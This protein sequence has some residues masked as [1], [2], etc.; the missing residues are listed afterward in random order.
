[1]RR[2]VP[3]APPRGATTD[4]LADY[5]VRELGR[6]NDAI[7]Q[8]PDLDKDYGSPPRVFDGMLR[9]ADGVTWNPDATH[10][11][12]FY[13]YW[14]GEWHYLACC[15]D[16]G[17]GGGSSCCV[18]RSK[19][20]YTGINLDNSSLQSETEFSDSFVSI[21][22]QIPD[23]CSAVLVGSVIAQMPASTSSDTSTATFYL[24]VYKY[25]ESS[26]FA[27][28]GTATL[29]APIYDDSGP[30]MTLSAT[31][32]GVVPLPDPGAL[33]GPFIVTIVGS[34]TNQNL[35]QVFVKSQLTA[36]VLPCIPP[37]PT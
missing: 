6:V 17:G 35:G 23:T 30:L 25:G 32:T 7:N 12:G 37:P 34:P 21:P 10:G 14:D 2:Y 16:G 22:A 31:L 11:E 26:P 13:G 8:I 27:T 19:Q 28:F 20:D 29:T 3:D 33:G 18:V 5:L 36:F 4:Q 24:Y 15:D 9:Y 1:M